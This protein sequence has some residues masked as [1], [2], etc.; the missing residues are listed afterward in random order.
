MCTGLQAAALRVAPNKARRQFLVTAINAAWAVIDQDQ[1]TVASGADAATRCG[2][3]C[4]VGQALELGAAALP[5]AT[6][7]ARTGAACVIL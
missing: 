3:M 6:A 7:G 5:L 4:C 2:M 1:A